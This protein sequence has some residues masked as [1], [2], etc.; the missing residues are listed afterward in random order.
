MKFWDSLNLEQRKLLLQNLACSAC[1][2][3]LT[4]FTLFIG[5]QIVLK[6]NM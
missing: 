2:L 4:L 5:E 3:F 1:I 6:V